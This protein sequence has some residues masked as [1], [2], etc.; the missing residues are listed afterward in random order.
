MTTQGAI[1]LLNR[2][3]T[4]GQWDAWSPDVLFERHGVAD[5]EVLPRYPFRDDGMDLW[6]ATLEFTRAYVA[7][8]YSKD[9]DVALDAEI[10][11]LRREMVSA[12][13]MRLREDELDPMQTRDGLARVIAQIIFR[14]TT[15]H[16]VINYA[17]Y[18]SMGWVP[19]MPTALFAP[20]PDATRPE[21]YDQGHLR[22]MM[23]PR[24]CALE[25][26]MDVW[27]VAT[28]QLNTLGQYP[29]FADGR[30]DPLIR[31]FQGRLSS[32]EHTFE[33]RNRRRPGDFWYLL[34]SRIAASIHV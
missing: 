2:V 6:E 7:L 27:M 29:E 18:D 22:Q 31:R 10:R 32:L 3:F 30:V 11:D 34:P 21:E 28:T 13:G 25:T 5:A 17:V 33:D 9:E 1:D 15:Y 20:A 16:N 14:V 24:G 4:G 12:Q 8:Y 23:S 19:N 26:L